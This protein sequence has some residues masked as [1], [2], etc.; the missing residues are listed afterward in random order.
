VGFDQ[1]LDLVATIPMLDEW[2]KSPYLAGMRGK[3]LTIP[4]QGTL[5]APKI[6]ADLALQELTRSF[7]QGAPG[8]LIDDQL[9]K[10]LDK[11]F[12]PKQ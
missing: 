11:L 6:D 8:R 10:G 3:S 9:K 4:V 5:A 1:S 7:L 2:T 12:G